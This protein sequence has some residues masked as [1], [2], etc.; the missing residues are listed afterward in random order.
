MNHSGV[1]VAWKNRQAEL[2]V[3]R[4]ELSKQVSFRTG[5]MDWLAS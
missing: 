3:M 1:L 2:G 4:I 5:E